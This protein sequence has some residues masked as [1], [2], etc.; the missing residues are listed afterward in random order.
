MFFRN[1][2]L[3]RFP[4]SL[5]FSDLDAHL[6][7]RALVSLNAELRRREAILREPVLFL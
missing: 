7:S 2:T 3:F 4:T 1:L 6:A 5:D